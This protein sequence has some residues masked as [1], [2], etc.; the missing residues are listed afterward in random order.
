[1]S[2]HTRALS[3]GLVPS[4]LSGPEADRQIKAFL[5]RCTRAHLAVAYWGANAVKRLGISEA[6]QRGADIRVVFDIVSGACNPDEVKDLR[7]VLGPEKVRTRDGLHAKA[8]IADTGCVLGSSNASANGLGHEANE[9]EGLI[10]ANLAFPS[11]SAEALAGWEAWFEEQVWKNARPLDNEMLEKAELRWR[12]RRNNRDKFGPPPSRGVTLVD[13][14]I[15]DPDYFKDKLFIVTVYSDNGISDSAEVVLAAA[16]AELHDT[17]K[18]ILC[19]ENWDLEPGTVVLDMHWDSKRKQVKEPSLWQILS[20]NPKRRTEGGS[21]T[22][23]RKIY[24]FQGLKLGPHKK[25]LLELSK[26]LMKRRED[27]CMSGGEFGRAIA[28]LEART[29]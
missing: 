5:S 7:D 20:D 23:C 9:I 22:L 13:R 12:W 6:A 3:T 27:L 18:S 14:L 16:Q 28:K 29:G 1:M 24:D 10:E 2:R 21:I 26:I 4:I 19:Y 15:N 8:W 25:K 11:P 17:T